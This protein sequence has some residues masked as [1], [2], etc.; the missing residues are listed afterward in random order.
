MDILILT[1]FEVLSSAG[2]RIYLL[3][4]A[5]SGLNLAR[6]PVKTILQ[7]LKLS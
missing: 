6:K 2:R 1:H 4:F 5:K 3:C 7:A